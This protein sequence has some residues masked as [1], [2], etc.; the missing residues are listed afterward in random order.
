MAGTEEMT[1]FLP[2]YRN[3]LFKKVKLHRPLIVILHWV[4]NLGLEKVSLE[5]GSY[6]KYICQRSYRG[7]GE[8]KSGNISLITT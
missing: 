2:T 6:V 1:K 4:Y 3:V 5:F 8:N 7:W